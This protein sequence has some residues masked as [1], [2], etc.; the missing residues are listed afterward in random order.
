MSINQTFTELVKNI[1]DKQAYQRIL[2]KSKF[3]DDIN[4]GKLNLLSSIGYNLIVVGNTNIE[5][6]VNL[7]IEEIQYTSNFG[8]LMYYRNSHLEKH[9]NFVAII[10]DSWVVLDSIQEAAFVVENLEF[11][12]IKYFL[13]N[14]SIMLDD[15]D[16]DEVIKIFLEYGISYKNFS[17]LLNCTELIDVKRLTRSFDK[18]SFSETKKTLNKAHKL[19]EFSDTE[20]QQLQNSKNQIQSE[21][22]GNLRSDLISN[23]NP[24]HGFQHSV[25]ESAV[26]KNVFEQLKNIEPIEL[27]EDIS[28]KIIL[29]DLEPLDNLDIN[30]IAT[31]NTI[32]FEFTDSELTNSLQVFLNG[33]ELTSINNHVRIELP[34]QSS[35]S[36]LSFLHRNSQ[37]K[38]EIKIQTQ[39]NGFKLRFYN[40]KKIISGKHTIEFDRQTYEVNKIDFNKDV[41]FDI[42]SFSNLNIHTEFDSSVIYTKTHDLHKYSISGFNSNQLENLLL[43]IEESGTATTNLELKITPADVKSKIRNYTDEIEKWRIRQSG[44]TGEIRFQEDIDPLDE[45]WHHLINSQGIVCFLSLDELDQ[46]VEFNK[47]VKYIK[48]ESI[49]LGITET[50]YSLRLNNTETRTTELFNDFLI[51]RDK[52]LDPFRKSENFNK[53]RRDLLSLLNK[54]DKSDITGYANAYFELIRQ[55]SQFC[56]IDTI[57]LLKPE[58]A[59][60]RRLGQHN[61]CGSILPFFHPVCI[62][63]FYKYSLDVND[64]HNPTLLKSKP[65]LIN[66]Y[67]GPE[68]EIFTRVENNSHL[69]SIFISSINGNFRSNHQQ[70]RDSIK[71]YNITTIEDNVVLGHSDILKALDSLFNYVPF[72]YSY[73]IAILGKSDFQIESI[74]GDYLNEITDLDNLDSIEIRVYDFRDDTS[75]IDEGYLGL[76]SLNSKYKLIWYTVKRTDTLPIELKF[77]L[78]LDLSLE[79]DMTPKMSLDSESNSISTDNILTS[80][81]QTTFVQNNK[82]K[83]TYYSN[84]NSPAVKYFVNKSAAHHSFIREYYNSSSVQNSIYQS[85]KLIATTAQGYYHISND[86]SNN[87][88]L[89]ELH[90]SNNDYQF[91]NK[92][93]FYLTINE[94]RIFEDRLHVAFESILNTIPNELETSSFLKELRDLNLFQFKF[95]LSSRNKTQGLIGEAWIYKNYY[96]ALLKQ[97]GNNFVMLPYDLIHDNLYSALNINGDL[98]DR[99][100]PDFLCLSFSNGS[101]YVQFLEVKTYLNSPSPRFN[102]IFS[103]QILP[104]QTSILQW[105][106]KTENSKS[107]MLAFKLQILQLFEISANN[108]GNKFQI[109]NDDLNDWLNQENPSVNIKDPIL[110][111]ISS[112]EEFEKWSFEKVPYINNHSYLLVKCTFSEINPSRMNTELD[113]L[114]SKLSSESEIKTSKTL[115]QEGK[116]LLNESLKKAADPLKDYVDPTPPPQ[117][118]LTEITTVSSRNNPLDVDENVKAETKRKMALVAAKLRAFKIN[119]YPKADSTVFGPSSIKCYFEMDPSVSINSIVNK[120]EDIA[121]ALMLD[122]GQSVNVDHEKGLCTIEFPRADSDR[123]YFE[124]NDLLHSFSRSQTELIIP[125]GIDSQGKTVTINFSSSQT[126]HLLIGG[127][128]GSGKSIALKTILTAATRLY[129]S[130][131]LNLTL[132]DPKKVELITFADLPHLLNSEIS[133]IIGSSSEETINYLKKAISIM[134]DRYSLFQQARVTNLSE[135]NLKTSNTLSRHLIVL[136]EY[137]DIVSNEELRSELENLLEKLSQKARAAGIHLIITTQKPSA[138]VLSTVIRS[139]LPAQLAL[140]VSRVED[141]R[142]ILGDNSGAQKLN[143]K[144]DALFNTGFGSP[145]RLQVANS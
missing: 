114:F 82:F 15:T 1:I 70:I 48:T 96:Q 64:S 20:F 53:T 121:I 122:R 138:K 109:N 128:T 32:G 33:K 129:S 74:I 3:I 75:Q 125:F 133:P 115:D 13:K 93:D 24:K 86:P 145:V 29:Y 106:K 47:N 44:F 31:Q 2:F 27:I 103:A 130:D 118:P 60:N 37:W 89:Y 52:V 14:G 66:H 143:G 141:S 17:D 61:I 124:I 38:R 81:C 117:V 76:Y 69:Y 28:K 9:K 46:P 105:I 63:Y 131:E 112:S 42:I 19:L 101:L 40:G 99:H 80:V 84:F 58:N 35:I 56:N 126:P 71:K 22:L 137:A 132:V 25:F 18:F 62:E 85:S 94:N 107:L 90:M 8:D 113:I 11:E 100:H 59:S 144:G 39:F 116:Y 120:D 88:L 140:K 45:Y 127:Q 77:D 10:P 73:N 102:D 136:D 54:I 134:E 26:I 57:Y 30:F 67:N 34:Q 142:V 95:F 72:K 97:Y 83:T 65:K 36:S 5:Q 108:Y 119:I 111:Y 21:I 123:V 92:G 50:Q 78:L 43:T 104:V 87:M 16:I 12:M 23:F 91:G 49:D 7:S 55:S 135:F 139:N 41:K 79:M 51:F 68:N 98:K 4:F 110:F 6:P